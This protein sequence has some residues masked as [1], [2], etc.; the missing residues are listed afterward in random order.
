MYTILEGLGLPRL[1]PTLTETLIKYYKVLGLQ[2]IKHTMT[3][4]SVLSVNDEGKFILE[5]RCCTG[6][7]VHFEDRA[8]WLRVP[9]LQA[10]ILCK[11]YMIECNM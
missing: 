2:S 10:T 1:V 3:T 7:P 6:I 8:N 4:M 5:Y 11:K 9:E